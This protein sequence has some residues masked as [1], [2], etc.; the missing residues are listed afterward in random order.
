MT[1]G[2]FDMPM[3][4]YLAAH[5]ISQSGLKTL[6][7]S[8]AHYQ[9]AI[10]NP[11]PSTP[12]QQIGIICHYAV[13]QPKL[14]PESHWVKPETYR[15]KNS[16]WKKWH[17]GATACK[18]WVEAH[19]DRLVISQAEFDT[20]EAMRKS[21]LAHPAAAMALRAGE[22]EKSLFCEDADTGL[23]LKCRSDFLSGNAIVDLKKCQDASPAG[24]AKTIAAYGYDIQAAVNLFICN[25][26]GLAKEHFL[27]IAVEDK[28][29]YAVG[30]Y[31]LTDASVEIGH[32]KFRRL[33]GRYM[34]CVST[35]KWPAY[36]PNVEYLSLPKWAQ[37]AEFSA[38]LADE[39]PVA[40]ALAVE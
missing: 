34:E 30:V 20:I 2:V 29:P 35:D 1:T 12:D 13:F 8:P 5:G 11:K 17:G 19:K 3:A 14:F 26:L 18:D 23:Q 22:A 6:A 38:Q 24:F 39:S 4:D 15:D 25:V 36:S 7:R 33:L 27:F 9:E 16:D 21:V 40:P 28:P 31:K 32:S 10:A 37:S